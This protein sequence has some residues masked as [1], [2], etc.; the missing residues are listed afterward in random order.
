MVGGEIGGEA[1]R[2]LFQEK[3]GILCMGR[4]SYATADIG[5]IATGRDKQSGMHITTDA[6]AEIVEPATG[7]QLAC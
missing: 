7:K 5:A 6:V 3:Y 2:K 1:L 4:D